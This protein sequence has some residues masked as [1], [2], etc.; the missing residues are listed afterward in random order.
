MCPVQDEMRAGLA[1]FV[2]VIFP[3]LPIFLR[4]LDNCLKNI[5]QGRIPLTHA[6]FK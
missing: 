3:T 1:S 5:G 4:R 2:D 6:P